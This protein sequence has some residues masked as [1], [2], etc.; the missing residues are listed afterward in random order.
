M[1]ASVGRVLLRWFRVIASLT[2]IWPERETPMVFHSPYFSPYAGVEEAA[3]QFAEA[4]VCH[5]PNTRQPGGKRRTNDGV[6]S[7]QL[8]RRIGGEHEGID[9]RGESN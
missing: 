3:Q 6:S 4:R 8:K 1:E 9:E 5:D 2:N 7:L